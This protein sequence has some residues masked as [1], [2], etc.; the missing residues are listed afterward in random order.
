VFRK[1]QRCWIASGGQAA[2]DTVC[3]IV[4]ARQ[5]QAANIAVI[6]FMA[7]GDEQPTVV[8]AEDGQAAI[9]QT[10]DVMIDGPVIAELQ[11]VETAAGAAAPQASGVSFGGESVTLL[12][13]GTP[14][15]IGFF[16]HWCPHCQSEVDQLSKHLAVTGLPDDVNV[17]A[18][19]TAVDSSRANFPPSAWFESEGWP[20]PVLSDDAESSVAKSY[21]L[22]GFPFW[23]IVDAEGEI[24]ARSAGGIGPDEFDA[25]LELARA[26]G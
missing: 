22:S 17:V 18:V 4:D 21:G 3:V 24:V 9:A 6:V 10:N 25:Y 15:V 11:E 8:Q 2:T 26:G 19:S 20:G 12:E 16:A 7:G 23:A 13:P 5:P 14:T 1:S